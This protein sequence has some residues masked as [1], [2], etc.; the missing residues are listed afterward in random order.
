MIVTKA[1]QLQPAEQQISN[2]QSQMTQLQNNQ[3]VTISTIE[4]SY[5]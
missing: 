4:Q 1:T 5:R 3:Q 2:L